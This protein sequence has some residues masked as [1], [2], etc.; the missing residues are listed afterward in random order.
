MKNIEKLK[1]LNASR[2]KLE[3]GDND[4]LKMAKSKL[5]LALTKSLTMTYVKEDSKGFTINVADAAINKLQL[6]RSNS[7]ETNREII[8]NNIGQVSSHHSDKWAQLMS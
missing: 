1:S 2:I 3:V 8:W 4:K 6:N 7:K 5:K